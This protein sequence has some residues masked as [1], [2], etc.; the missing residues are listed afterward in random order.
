M[1]GVKVDVKQTIE[2]ERTSSQRS[3]RLL[4]LLDGGVLGCSSRGSHSGKL[5]SDDGG[6]IIAATSGSSG[7]AQQDP[8]T[9]DNNDCGK[10]LEALQAQHSRRL[11]SFSSRFCNPPNYYRSPP[12]N[13]AKTRD[14]SWEMAD[15]TLHFPCTPEKGTRLVCTY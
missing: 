6:N 14:H 7:L 11:C 12:Q 8:S 1:I 13:C 5:W 4:A 9:P 3:S 10:L 2:K 15:R